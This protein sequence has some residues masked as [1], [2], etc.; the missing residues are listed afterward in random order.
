MVNKKHIFSIII[1]V[2]SLL[3]IIFVVANIFVMSK[4]GMRTEQE[5]NRLIMFIVATGVF[6]LALVFVIAI[7]IRNYRKQFI[8][9]EDEEELDIDEELL[10]EYLKEEQAQEN[11]KNSKE[12]E[13]E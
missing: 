4:Q 7:I 1:A 5:I 2:L 9:E 11:Q 8:K 12:K 13:L 6:I 10:Q 3:A